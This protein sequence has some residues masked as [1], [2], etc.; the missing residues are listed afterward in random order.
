MVSKACIV[1]PYQRKLEELAALPGVDLTVVVPPYWRE[2]GQTIRLDREHT[3]GYELVVEPMAL[4]GHFHL[5]FYPSLARQFRRVR[6]DV[7]HIDEEPY[8]LATFHALRLAQRTGARSL[9]FT[10]QNLA[11]RYPP[12]WSWVESYV[13]ERADYAIAGNREALGV[14]VQK[15][16]SGP[17]AVI[18][19]FGV[20][21]EIYRPLATVDG[22]SSSPGFRVG[23][24]GRL[25]EQKGVHLLLRA[26]AELGGEWSLSVLGEGPKRVA[27]VTLAE[28]LGISKRVEFRKP[29]P[30]TQMPEFLN[31]LDVLVLPSVTRPNWK[32]Q[33]GRVLVEAMACGTPV[34][35]SDSGEIPHVIGGAGMTFPEGDVCELT[36][37]LFRLRG[38]KRLRQDL[39]EEGRRRVLERFTQARVAAETYRV[40]REI[41]QDR[42]AERRMGA[43]R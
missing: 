37:S 23:Y 19:Q 12:P 40:Y 1:G 17:S 4:N 42:S 5:H 31:Q 10:W 41:L 2:A 7:C 6:P 28:E 39:A 34:V 30:S 22:I 15:G 20:D 29:I 8:N 21:P 18:P 25:V 13:L 3:S 32:E 26:L 16:Y 38:D 33:F 11:R 24:A 36:R 35:G 9:F 14:L 43:G 27:L